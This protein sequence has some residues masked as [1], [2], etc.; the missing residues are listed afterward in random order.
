[1]NNVQCAKRVERNKR[2]Y[3]NPKKELKNI[4]SQK[5]KL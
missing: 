3:R 2:E 4:A 5:K 1:M